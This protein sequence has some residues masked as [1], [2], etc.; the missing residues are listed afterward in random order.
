[1]DPSVAVSVS[2]SQS[3]SSSSSH[4]N[5]MYTPAS[6]SNSNPS[7]SSKPKPGILVSQH[8]GMTLYTQLNPPA[9]DFDDQRVYG[10][11]LYLKFK[12]N[13]SLFDTYLIYKYFDDQRLY[14]DSLAP[15]LTCPNLKDFIDYYQLTS[16]TL[17]NALQQVEYYFSPPNLVKDKFMLQSKDSDDFIDIGFVSNFGKMKFILRDMSENQR[18]RIVTLMLRDSPMVELNATETRMRSIP[19]SAMIRNVLV[20]RNI[21]PS[22]TADDIKNLVNSEA[23]GRGCNCFPADPLYLPPLSSFAQDLYQDT[24]QWL[25]QFESEEAATS[26][27][28]IVTK[29]ISLLDN[30]VF[31]RVL[32]Q[33]STAYNNLLLPAP[34]MRLSDFNPASSEQYMI[35][36]ISPNQIIYQQPSLPPHQPQQLLQ[37]PNSLGSLQQQQ[38]GLQMAPQQAPL[39]PTTTSNYDATLTHVI[40]QQQLQHPPPPTPQRQ[41]LYP[42]ALHT[43]SIP[44]QGIPPNSQFRQQP[45]QT[46]QQQQHHQPQPQTQLQ[47]KIYQQFPTQG[48][49]I[50]Q[51][52]AT[53]FVCPQLFFDP[54][55]GG[56]VPVQFPPQQLVTLGF[57]NRLRGPIVVNP[58]PNPP[59]VIPQQPP[60]APPQ[61]QQQ[62]PTQQQQ[63][64]QP[65]QTQQLQQPPQQIVQHQVIATSTTATTFSPAA[66]NSGNNNSSYMQHQ[67]QQQM[68]HQHMMHMSTAINNNNSSN[69]GLQQQQPHQ[70]AGYG[71]A[72]V[73]QNSSS[74]NK[75]RIYNGK[76]PKYQNKNQLQ[77]QQQQQQLQQQ[78]QQQQQ[79]HINQNIHLFLQQHQQQSQQQQQQQQQPHIPLPQ[80]PPQQLQQQ[81]QQHY[82]Q[83]Q[84]PQQ[85]QPTTTAATTQSSSVKSELLSLRTVTTPDDSA[86]PSANNSAPS[87]VRQLNKLNLEGSGNS[88]SSL[89]SHNPP[90]NNN[91]NNI[92]SVSSSS[93]TTDINVNHAITKWHHQ[94]Q[95][96]QQQPVQQQHQPQHHQPQ[97]I[98]FHQQQQPQQPQPAQHHHH[99]QQ[100][101][102]SKNSYQAHDQL[103]FHHNA[104]QGYHGNNGN[105]Y[106]G[107]STFH[108][109]QQQQQHHGH[110]GQSSVQTNWRGSRDYNGRFGTGGNVGGRAR[111]GGKFDDPYRNRNNNN[112]SNNSRIPQQQQQHQQQQ[113][114]ASNAASQ[115]ATQQLQQPPSPSNSELDNSN[116]P[117]LTCNIQASGAPSSQVESTAHHV[118]QQSSPPSPPTSS[119]SLHH[120]QQQQQQS[121]PGSLGPSGQHNIP[122]S[123]FMTSS[124]MKTTAAQQS[125]NKLVTPPNK[126]QQHASTTTAAIT[127]LSPGDHPERAKMSYAQ[128]IKGKESALMIPPA[129]VLTS[130]QS[131]LAVGK[132]EASMTSPT[133]TTSSNQQATA[134]VRSLKSNDSSSCEDITETAEPEAKEDEA[135][136]S[137]HQ[138]AATATAA[139]PATSNA[140]PSTNTSSATAS[141][142]GNCMST[143]SSSSSSGPMMH[144]N[145]QQH[146]QQHQSFSRKGGAGGH[147]SMKRGGG[148]GAVVSI[149]IS[150]RIVMYDNERISS[151]RWQYNDADDDCCINWKSCSC[152][153]LRF[154]SGKTKRNGVNIFASGETKRYGYRYN[155]C[156][157]VVHRNAANVASVAILWHLTFCEMVD[158]FFLIQS[159]MRILYHNLTTASRISLFRFILLLL[160]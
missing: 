135:M 16:Y 127:E 28:Q 17:E 148:S 102:G 87:F 79:Q 75:Q 124:S 119:T 76:N 26:I 41:Y 146:Q 33:S 62:P 43:A 117:P 140:A 84:Q 22:C 118:H 45:Q 53:P 156:C 145:R 1:M 48:G 13:K 113:H 35:N 94:Q 144:R 93:N 130:D 154:A 74:N 81:Q 86:A 151:D 123:T 19:L 68:L 47:P 132:K 110:Y 114:V 64:Q 56:Y 72:S 39:L 24:N 143:S 32:L 157:C 71:V 116:F 125:G 63:Q 160:Q 134:A 152:I 131:I 121:P 46:P 18:R 21:H 55:G 149:C 115:Q 59:M 61:Q 159:L 23:T 15:P 158:D 37:F 8:K 103:N 50:Y 139:G 138:Q 109:Q 90:S 122:T 58:S 3:D 6:Q 97:E 82:H 106:H 38:S 70:H 5:L 66:A 98:T 133:S 100:H 10:K 89:A 12:L 128:I 141:A 107:N 77:Q 7:N 108:L 83:L 99:Q 155:C 14:D 36:Y 96:H 142:T 85:Q 80:P 88:S 27:Y 105:N 20:F 65:Q 9:A 52:P 136:L 111:R 67:H 78:Q 4:N 49:I 92:S 95:Q 25:V 153:S 42:A 34:G 101:Y 69:I 129:S 91:N 2:Y 147:S 137:H 112:N 126:Q 51:H 44:V 11:N 30:Q 120:N 60:P 31:V 150:V 104:Y 73:G 29:G 57:N 40:N 54:T